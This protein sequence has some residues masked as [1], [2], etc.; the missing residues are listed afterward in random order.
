MHT[1]IHTYTYMHSQVKV[2]K[3][4]RLSQFIYFL[5]A[6]NIRI[7]GVIAE[8]NYVSLA[9]TTCKLFHEK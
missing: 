4:G 7:P 1:Y 5:E 3:E 8:R 6:A 9:E 2:G